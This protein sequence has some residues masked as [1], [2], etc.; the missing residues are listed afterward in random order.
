MKLNLGC[1]TD[2]KEGYINIDL[3][4]KHPNVINEDI[5]NISFVQENTVDEIYAK[6]ILEHIPYDK[7][8][9]CLKIWHTWL[10]KDGILFIQT[11]NFIKFIQ[12]FSEKIWD[13]RNLNY[14]LFSG[15]SWTGA[16]SF[17]CDFHK[18]I[19]TTDFLVNTLTNIGYKIISIHEDE[20]DNN[21]KCNGY[22][23][24]LNTAITAKKI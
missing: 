20:I 14:M 3:N 6:D 11:T 22:S 1:A 16:Q 4:Y 23:H 15:V 7:A 9:D 17:D 13:L 21:L 8:V 19:F 2:I 12:A 18:S 24:N 5:S 10:K